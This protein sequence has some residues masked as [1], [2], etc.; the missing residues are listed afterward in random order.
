MGAVLN[1]VGK[2]EDVPLDDLEYLSL[3]FSLASLSIQERWRNNLL[4]ASFMADYFSSFFP[5][6]ETGIRAISAKAEVHSLIKYIANEL[7]ENCVKFHHNPERKVIMTLYLQDERLIFL[8]R[9]SINPLNLEAFTKYIQ[10]LCDNDPT[11]L[12]F[13]Q[14][15][16]N[17]LDENN[18]SSGLGLLTMMHDYGSHLG[19]KFE[20]DNGDIVI[21]TQ[22][23]VPL[24]HLRPSEE[25]KVPVL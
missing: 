16:K 25:V 22:V 11:E 8:A 14:L 5:G 1:I 12:Y 13:Q 15:E 2:Y 4:S 17:A 3:V 18:H 20:E 7:L 23:Q 9:N 6:N 24:G 19:W 10:T 21:T